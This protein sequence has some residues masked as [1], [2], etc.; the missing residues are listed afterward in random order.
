[1]IRKITLVLSTTL[2]TFFFT[3]AQSI[4]E[5]KIYE[6]YDQLV[7]LE[8]TSLYNGTEFT[9][10]YLN[11]NGTY[12]YYNGYDYSR[13]SVT[14][15]GQYYVN[16]LLKYDPLEDN[17]LTRSDDNLSIFNIKLIPSFV[18]S[19][20]IYNHRFV[21]L[22]DTNLDIAGNGFFEAAYVGNQ[23][24]LYIKHTKKKKDKAIR[25]GVQYRFSEDNFY[26][27]KLDDKYA[28]VNSLKTF[29]ELL[30]K[31]TEEI[32]KFYKSYKALYKSN[33]D[34][35]MTNLVKYLDSPETETNQ[36]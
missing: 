16:V 19:F 33:P 9:D 2:F 24:G 1:M 32:R 6:V 31:K 30:P 29:R 23:L 5:Q 26:I 10:L 15:D 21:R 35:F 11:T 7:G 28:L 17:L 14:Y 4:A 20:S 8:N 36:Q 34:I 22:S 3:T 12:R 13:G 18:D 25:T 27:I